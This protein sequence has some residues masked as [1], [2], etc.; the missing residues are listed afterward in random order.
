MTSWFDMCPWRL[1]GT[2]GV[3]AEDVIPLRLLRNE[4]KSLV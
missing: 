3:Y 1:Q 4:K 2:E